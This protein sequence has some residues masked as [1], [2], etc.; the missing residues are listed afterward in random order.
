MP[1]TSDAELSAMIAGSDADRIYSGQGHPF[2][3][4][5]KAFELAALVGADRRAEVLPLVVD[6][7]MGARGRAFARRFE[8]D[9]GTAR[10]IHGPVD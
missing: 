7:V 6:G 4:V 2:D 9:P 8:F 5:N 3:A 10:E 1:E